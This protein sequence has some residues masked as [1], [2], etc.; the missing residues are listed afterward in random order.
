MAAFSYRVSSL[1]NSGEKEAVLDAETVG[2][3]LDLTPTKNVIR[4]D[5]AVKRASVQEVGTLI[6]TIIPLSVETHGKA[7][8]TVYRVHGGDAEPLLQDNGRLWQRSV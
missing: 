5:D 7:S 3:Y 8:Y 6:E 1:V 2:L 4:N